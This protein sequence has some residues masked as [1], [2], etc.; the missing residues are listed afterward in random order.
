MKI[1]SK[2]Y[3]QA[4][5]QLLA[6]S[7]DHKKVVAD[8]INYLQK[9]NQLFKFDNIISEIEAMYDEASSELKVE[10]SSARKLNKETVDSILAYVKKK[11]AKKTLKVVEKIDD[12][13]LGAFVIRYE[14]KLIDGSLKYNLSNFAKHL[15]N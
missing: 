1:S 5:Y 14:D 11:S 10:L 2:Q 15:S 3:A 13:L 8:F 12:K 6:E 4:L 7:N 9:N